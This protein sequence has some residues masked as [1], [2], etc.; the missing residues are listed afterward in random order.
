MNFCIPRED[1]SDDALA[2]G[3]LSHSDPVGRTL[4]EMLVHK[5]Q[6]AVVYELDK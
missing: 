4:L 3:C 5:K 2:P 1:I 6:R